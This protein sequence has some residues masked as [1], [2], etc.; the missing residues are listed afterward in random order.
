MLCAQVLGNLNG[1]LDVLVAPSP[2][3]DEGDSLVFK[4]EGGARLGSF[5]NAVFHLAVDGGNH[6]LVAKDRLGEGDGDFTPNIEAIPVEDGVGPDA[7]IDVQVTGRPAVDA[8][9][10]LTGYSEGLAVIDTGGDVDL[11]GLVDTNPTQA[12]TSR[13]GIGNDFSRYNDIF[14]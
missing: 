8:H 12:V 11:D 9:I 5:V 1:D 2:A 14:Y 13:T 10:P 6:H 4:P 7:D 3:I